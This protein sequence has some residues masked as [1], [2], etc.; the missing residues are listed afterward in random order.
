ML[1]AVSRN[2]S[3]CWVRT[4]ENTKSLPSLTDL[5]FISSSGH[6]LHVAAFKRPLALSK[7][8]PA[9]GFMIFGMPRPVS[10]LQLDR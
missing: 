5:L 8:W 6:Q 10:C 7:V 4:A 9:A 1:A 3:W 2:C